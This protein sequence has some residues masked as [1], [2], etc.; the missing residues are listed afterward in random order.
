MLIY[1]KLH[2]SRLFII[3]LLLVLLLWALT[4]SIKLITTENK[5]LLVRI[6]NFQTQIV[7]EGISTPLPVEIE[8]FINEFFGFF[9]SYNSFNYD[10]HIDRALQLMNRD[11]ALKFVPK[12]NAMSEKA[13]AKSIWQ[14]SYA[15]EIVNLKD[16]EFEVKM[17]VTRREDVSESEDDFIIKLKLERVQRTAQNPY[18]L[19][20]VELYED[21]T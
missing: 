19:E 1:L 10:T 14:S 8:N 13:K 7:S 4:V 15:V 6:D 16:L 3:S 9:Y 5:T 21:Y 20:V 11:C 17:R 12:L 2:Q 18:G